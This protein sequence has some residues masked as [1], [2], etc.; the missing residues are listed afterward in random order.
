LLLSEHEGNDILSSMDSFIEKIQKLKG[1]MLGV[2]ISAL[3]LAPLAVGISAY[4]I[5]HP[6]FLLL[7]EH[8]TEFGFML[9]ILLT[10][11]LIT[12]GV[13]L[14]NGIKQ[15][16]SLS[17]WNKRYCNYLAKRESLDES[18]TSKFHLDKD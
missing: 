17:S 18:I 7:I 5:S 6:R 16:K 14:V 15:L 9:F 13:W 4:L 10:V 12:S 3:I 2:S 11:V 8:E 1:I